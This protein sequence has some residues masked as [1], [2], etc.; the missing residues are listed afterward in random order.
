MALGEAG[1]ATTT[2][3]AMETPTIRQLHAFIACLLATG[4]AVS[5]FAQASPTVADSGQVAEETASTEAADDAHISH[6]SREQGQ[7][8]FDGRFGSAG[9]LGR[10]DKRLGALRDT[11]FHLQL[12]SY[13][14]NRDR[15]DGSRSE[16]WTAG[17]WA[18]LKTGYFLDRV[19]V[20]LTGYTSQHLSGSEDNGGTLLLARGQEGYSVLGELYADIRLLED[21][22]LYAGRMEYDTP[23]INRHDSRMTP[24][25]FEAISLL[26][27]ATLGQG[28]ETISYGLGYFD[29]IKTVNSDEFVSMSQ[30]AGATV[31]RGVFTA[32]GM[33]TKGDFSFGAIDYYSPDV[34]NIAY[35]EARYGIPLGSDLRLGLAAQFSD[36]RSVGDDLLAG[37]AFDA[38]QLG[39]KAEISWGGALFSAAYTK[40]LG[41]AGM[42][43]PWG[44]YP[45]YSSVQVEN[46]N[47]EGEGA[48]LLRAAYHFNSIPGLSTY[49]LWVN[50]TDPDPLGQYRMDEFDANVEWAPPE[51]IFKGLSLRLRY[52]HVE[53]HGTP[54][55]GLNDFRAIANYSLEW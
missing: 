3:I 26:G 23:Y 40:T 44:G 54:A 35:A 21:Q 10:I 9:R 48:F 1:A 55:S 20:G 17:G 11:W 19:A 6:S 24:N 52:A 16:A 46:F 30:A 7:T 25:T 50:G 39:L 22:H 31:D 51:G 28:G 8:H 2:C 41:D 27:K 32:G 15:F 18:G 36:Q 12:R 29:K 43:S 49:V 37:A 38:Q 33:C 34:I 45:G 5:S 53:Q 47:R 4:G 42:R 13:Y 14:M